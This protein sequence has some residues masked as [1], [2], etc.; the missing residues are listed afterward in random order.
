M[1]GNIK[2]SEM[3][4]TFTESAVIAISGC[5][6]AVLGIS[7][8]SV[9]DFSFVSDGKFQSK[10]A[11][12]IIL[13]FSFLIAAGVSLLVDTLVRETI[14]TM[15][16][17]NIAGSVLMISR[18]SVNLLVKKWTLFDEESIIIYFLAGLLIYL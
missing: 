18:V 10:N 9:N 17:V 2:V 11:A 13:I 3:L 6:M 14:A 12:T 7:L 5:I 1:A 16:V 8:F 4:D 15:S